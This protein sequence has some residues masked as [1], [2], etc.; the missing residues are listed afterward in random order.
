MF[1]PIVST[2]KIPAVH[3]IRPAGAAVHLA[4]PLEPADDSI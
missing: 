3:P 4:E 1:S 2:R